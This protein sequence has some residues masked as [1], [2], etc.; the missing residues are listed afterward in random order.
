MGKKKKLGYVIE[1]IILEKFV[2]G[3]QALGYFGDR[4]VFVWGGLPG[5]TVDVLVIKARKGVLEGLAQD[6]RNKSLDRVEP[7][8]EY[9]YLSTSPWQILDFK[10]E[11]KVKLDLLKQTFKHEAGIDLGDDLIM[12]YGDDE[13]GYRNK[14]EYNFWGDEEGLHL[15]LHKRGSG[16]KIKLKGS[17]LASE[18]IND[19]GQALIGALNEKGVFAGDLKSLILRSSSDGKCVGALFIKKE[20]FDELELPECMSGLVCYY[21][22]PK[23]PASIITKEL[24]IKGDITLEDKVLDKKLK[25][26]VNSFFQLNIPVFEEALRD[27]K[28]YLKDGKIVDFYGGTGSIGVSLKDGKKELEIVE[29]DEHSAKMAKVNIKDLNNARVFNLSAEE[30]LEKIVKDSVLVVDP[31]RAGLHKKVVQKICE[32]KPKQLVY[33]SCNPVTQ[34]RDLK[35]I[36]ESGYKIEF[37]C[38]YNFFPRTPHIESL[39]ILEKKYE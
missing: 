25:Y 37:A 33:L 38:G 12:F 3:G 1:N 31:P 34:A 32:V 20:V 2:N 35:E 17:V 29:L 14:M 28:K 8:N 10:Y 18:S 16:Q 30:S 13:Y 21:S 11:N 7:A 23:S 27:I 26:D 19:A 24:W 22:N 36:I 9:E 15:A 4:P 5:E 6:I 39:V